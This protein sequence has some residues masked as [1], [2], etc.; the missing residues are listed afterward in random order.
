MW[1][2]AALFGIVLSQD[3][4]EMSVVFGVSVGFGGEKVLLNG[5]IFGR[6]GTYEV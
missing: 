5:R 4:A 6:R 3:A 1:E 2:L